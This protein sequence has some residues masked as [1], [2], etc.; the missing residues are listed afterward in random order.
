MK[1]EIAPSATNPTPPARVLLA[2]DDLEFRSL[3]AALLREDGYD[4]VE[5]EDGTELL[6]RLAEALA[7]EQGLDCYDLVV[8]DIRMPGH[9]AFDIMSG[10]RR[11]RHDTPFILIT[12]FG[13]AATHLRAQQLEAAALLDKPFDLDD[14]RAAVSR[15]L[16]RR[17]P[18]PY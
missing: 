3:L 1:A 12:A 2:E 15:A 16:S 10:L 5:A 4:V 14:L 11:C 7:S 9:D 13:D 18:L 8:S 6:N 17:P